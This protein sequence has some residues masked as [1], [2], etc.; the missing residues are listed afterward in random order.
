MTHTEETQILAELHERAVKLARQYGEI[1]TWDSGYE[2]SVQGGQKRLRVR[3]QQKPARRPAR[4]VD[5]DMD[6]VIVEDRVEGTRQV[7][8]VV[9]IKTIA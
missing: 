4:I 9:Q 3:F 7:A 8:G 5:E 1:M 2:M 6:G